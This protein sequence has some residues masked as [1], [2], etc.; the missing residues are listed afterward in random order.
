MNRHTRRALRRPGATALVALPV[1]AHAQTPVLLR[2]ADAPGLASVLRADV[3][4]MAARG[5]HAAAAVRQIAADLNATLATARGDPL[6]YVTA[7]T[8]HFTLPPGA[9]YSAECS[10]LASQAV[11]APRAIF[12]IGTP[13][14]DVA[15]SF[16]ARGSTEL[17]GREAYALMKRQAGSSAGQA[18]AAAVEFY[19]GHGF[20]IEGT[21]DELVVLRW[22]GPKGDPLWV[23]VHMTNVT[24]SFGSACAA[25][26]NSA[27]IVLSI[28]KRSA[29]S[30]TGAAR[31]PAATATALAERAFSAALAR[32]RISEDR[33][34]SL[35]AA[36]WQALV[37]SRDPAEAAQTEAMEGAP[38]LRAQADARRQNRQWVERHLATMRPLLEPYERAMGAA[39]GR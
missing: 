3:A 9:R 35:L 39:G 23:G 19:R 18:Q 15:E 21:V 38:A 30:A 24:A 28:A 5:A 2:D 34:N 27:L 22:K 37:E 33:Y 25:L 4:R 32:E 7:G 14:D 12:A 31:D 10:A 17:T 29:T 11:L 13:A 16:R 8:A 20:G 1:V 26:G 6:A 36:A